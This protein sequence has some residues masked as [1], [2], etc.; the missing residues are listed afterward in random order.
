MLSLYFDPDNDPAQRAAIREEFVRALAGFP[1]WAVQRAFDAWTK[2]GTRRPSP[3]EI[4]ILAQ[5]QL[6]PLTAE[7]QRRRKRDEPPQIDQNRPRVTPE[8]AAAILQRAGFTPN[9][10]QAVKRMPMAGPDAIRAEVERPA[11]WTDAVPAGCTD[12]D[13]IRAARQAAGLDEVQP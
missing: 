5:R 3:G 11:H 10:F 6:E 2:R 12:P 1:D 7:L 9:W 8:A 13:V 4:A